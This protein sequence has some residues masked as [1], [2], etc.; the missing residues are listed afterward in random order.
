MIFFISTV[1]GNTI[2][3]VMNM[4]IGG[5]PIGFGFALIREPDA[6]RNFTILPEQKRHAVMEQARHFS[7]KKE[8]QDLIDHLASGKPF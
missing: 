5:I 1:F 4:E 2:S 3:E 7:T 8:I 6:L